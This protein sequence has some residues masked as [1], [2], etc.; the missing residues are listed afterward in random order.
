[1]RR[2]TKLDLATFRDLV[3]ARLDR[4][5]VAVERDQI[6]LALEIVADVAILAARYEA[7]LRDVGAR[8]DDGGPP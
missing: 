3:R 7:S 2:E 5:D 6:D 1:M 8:D 4:L